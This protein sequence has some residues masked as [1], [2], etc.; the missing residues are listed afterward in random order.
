M[1]KEL[2]FWKYKSLSNVLIKNFEERA[3]EAEFVSDA[4][5]AKEKVKSL[6]P[7]D[8]SVAVG[9]SVTLKETGILELLRNGDYVFNDRYAASTE[10]EQRKVRLENYHV[11]YF[12]CSANAITMKGEIVQ[13]DGL[14]TRVSPMLYGPGKVIIVAG[15][16]KVV[17]D[18][19]AAFDRIRYIS[20]MNA[21]R[22]KL[23]TPC[24]D[25][26]ICTDCKSHDRICEDYVVITDS[27]FRPDHFTVI[28]VGEDLGL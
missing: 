15:M 6:L 17:N 25:T 23:K 24:V 5:S 26:G 21:K 16:N 22:L 8:S 2:Y 11:D 7:K 18:I 13:C 9:G 10:E 27:H 12:L 3:I 1:R 20:P 14:G 4:E 28:L 19:E